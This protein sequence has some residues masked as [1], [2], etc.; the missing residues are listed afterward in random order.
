MQWLQFM[1]LRR[2]LAL[3][4]RDIY[5][6][7]SFLP[8]VAISLFIANCI[9]FAVTFFETTTI[10]YQLAHEDDYGFSTVTLTCMIIT[11]TIY[12]ADYL[13]TFTVAGCWMDLIYR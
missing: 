10:K 5:S 11:Q 7:K 8:I 12:P 4:D 6:S 3:S 13:F 9:R 2:I 1:S